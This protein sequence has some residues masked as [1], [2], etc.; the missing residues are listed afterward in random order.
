MS[1]ETASPRYASIEDWPTAE[2]VAAL[3]ECQHAAVAAVEAASSDIARAVDLAAERMRRGG[4]LIYLGA[5]TSGRIAAQDAVELRPTFAWPEARSVVLMA[6]GGDAFLSAREGAEDRA[7]EAVAALDAIA[8]GAD[9]VVIGLAASGRTPYTLGGLAHARQ[10][11]ALTVGLYNNPG[12]EMAGIAE[13][14]LLLDTGPEPVAGST[15]MKAGTAQKVALNALSTGIMI[16]LGHVHRGMMVEMKPTNAKLAGRAVEMVAAL[17]G[18]DREVAAAA[19]HA[20]DDNVKRAVV[21]L[22]LGLTAAEAEL[23]LAAAGGELRRALD[24]ASHRPAPRPAEG[25]EI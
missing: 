25:D 9:D 3:V 23:A 16:R 15:R 2:M 21:M 8:T 10:L 7:T 22:A 11:G 6:G 18:A 14:A 1:T 17:T 19:L 13:I 4:R 24:N 12:G 20:A 5:G